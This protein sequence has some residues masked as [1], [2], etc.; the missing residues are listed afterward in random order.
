MALKT[1]LKINFKELSTDELFPVDG[2][3]SPA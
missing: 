1:H 3:A 2:I